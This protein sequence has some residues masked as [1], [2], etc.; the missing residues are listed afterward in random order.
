MKNLKENFQSDIVAKEN[1]CSNY[2]YFEGRQIEMQKEN[3]DM[4]IKN[5][6]LKKYLQNIRN[7]Y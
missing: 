6:E 1:I 2:N 7:K 4:K 5:L 3:L